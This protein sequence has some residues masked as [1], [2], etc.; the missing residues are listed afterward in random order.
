MNPSRLLEGILAADIFLLK[1]TSL[2]GRV[3]S[4]LERRL[5]QILSS[6]FKPQARKVVRS[7]VDAISGGKFPTLIIADCLL[8]LSTWVDSLE[9]SLE[10]LVGESYATAQQG[11]SSREVAKSGKNS[12]FD[13]NDRRNIKAITRVQRHYIGNWATI[14][15]AERIGKHV[16]DIFL[17]ENVQGREAGLLLKKRLEEDFGLIR[18]PGPNTAE[19]YFDGLAGNTIAVARS[20]GALDAM[21]KMGIENY[22]YRCNISER[23]CSRCLYLD[24]RSFSVEPVRERMADIVAAGPEQIKELHPWA[25]DVGELQNYLLRDGFAWPPL[26]FRCRCYVDVE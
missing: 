22:V 23:T 8:P 20:Y 10:I 3:F 14:R 9:S 1:A 26:H 24:G 7:A 25:R 19:S 17:R 11:I 2:D 15:L 6:S 5:F 21:G 4:S 16:R 18:T 12:P 13:P